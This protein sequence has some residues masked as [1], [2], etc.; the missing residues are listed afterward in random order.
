MDR[1][2]TAG[3]VGLFAVVQIGWCAALAAG[4]IWLV[5]G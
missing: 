2:W 3:L 4:V 1:F 5:A